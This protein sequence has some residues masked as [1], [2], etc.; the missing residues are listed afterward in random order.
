[1][2]QQP[3]AI[4]KDF[5][6]ARDLDD[7]GMLGDRPKRIDVGTVVPIDRRML[8]QIGPFSVRIS[9]LL[10]MRSGNYFESV[11]SEPFGVGYSHGVAALVFDADGL[12][13]AEF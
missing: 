6:L 12:A 9:V 8:A 4:E 1:R 5:R 10:V 13:R 3:W 7:I 2:D 11:E